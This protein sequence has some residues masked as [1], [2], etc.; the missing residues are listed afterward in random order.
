[1]RNASIA[2]TYKLQQ[3]AIAS[4]QA[5]LRNICSARILKL[6]EILKSNS[7]DKIRKR[8]KERY[9]KRIDSFPSALLQGMLSKKL[10]FK[11]LALSVGARVRFGKI[12]KNWYFVD[13]FGTAYWKSNDV[14]PELMKTKE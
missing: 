10:E 14:K 5:K 7:R 4:F 12:W 8:A 13:N 2:S 6:A 3:Q 9:N 11:V 1:M